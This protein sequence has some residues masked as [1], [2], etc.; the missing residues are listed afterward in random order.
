MSDPHLP[1]DPADWRSW[2][3]WMHDA[4]LLALSVDYER[5][6][7][8]L[9][10]DLWV[11]DPSAPPGEEREA[12][13]PCRMRVS[14]LQYCV[15]EPPDPRYMSEPSYLDAPMIDAGEGV[16]SKTHPHFHL[17]TST[18]ITLWIFVSNR[19]SFILL[20]GTRVEFHLGE[21]PPASDA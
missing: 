6:V 9:R 18:A 14:G 1:T 2:L 7:L 15:I 3:G 13:R 12:R 10:L 8:E 11:G 20:A 4:I 5:G 16:P 19:N 21:P 17:K